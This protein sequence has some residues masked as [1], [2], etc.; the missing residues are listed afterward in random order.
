[1]SCQ[2]PSW[3]RRRLGRMHA[4]KM[5]TPRAMRA[6]R[7]RS[8]GRV[9]IRRGGAIL[10]GWRA[11]LLIIDL[12]LVGVAGFAVICGRI[13][14]AAMALTAATAVVGLYVVRWRGVGLAR[15]FAAAFAR[16]EA[17]VAGA[18]LLLPGFAGDLVGAASRPRP[19]RIAAF[20]PPP[21]RWVRRRRRPRRRGGGEDGPWSRRATT[22]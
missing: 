6:R 9:D 10:R 19:R 20:T 15:R 18:L 2:A 11:H 13:G 22:T 4:A 1:M 12:P 5:D 17:P 16:D 8:G 14:A 7:P 21:R 3:N